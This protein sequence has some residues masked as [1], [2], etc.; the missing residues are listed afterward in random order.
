MRGLS[1]LAVLGLAVLA[2][3][4]APPAAGAFDGDGT[5]AKGSVILSIQAGGGEQNNVEGHGRLSHISFVNFTPRL[6]LLPFDP[7]GSG[8]VHGALETGLEA[9][10]QHYLEPHDANAEG[11]K[12]AVRYHFLG[13]GRLVPYVEANAGVG[14]TSLKVLEIR[15]TL[16][17]VLEAGTGLSYFVTDNLALTA[18]YRFQHIS[19]GNTE[20]PNRGFNSDTGTVGV[21]YFFH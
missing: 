13:A 12:A 7:I 10:F 4:A 21:S 14:G 8:W 18:G 2:L 3:G 6:S 19:N 1:A 16:N 5:F 17:F 11:L 9:W 15:S 20:R